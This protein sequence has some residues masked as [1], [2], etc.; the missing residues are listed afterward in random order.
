MEMEKVINMNKVI[1][2]VIKVVSSIVCVLSVVFILGSIPRTEIF[3]PPIVPPTDIGH[4]IPDKENALQG[5]YSK[6]IRFK[7]IHSLVLHQ[8]RMYRDS[9]TSKWYLAPDER[10]KI[11]CVINPEC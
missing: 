3:V 7:G 10:K 1:Q 4:V 5:T 6:D 9:E 11:S 8:P 2:P